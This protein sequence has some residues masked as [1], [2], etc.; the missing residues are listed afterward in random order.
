MLAPRSLTEV[1]GE[2]QDTQTNGMSLEQTPRTALNVIFFQKSRLTP[3]NSDV[4]STDSSGDG[5]QD[6]TKATRPSLPSYVDSFTSLLA[7]LVPHID[8]KSTRLLTPHI[9]Q[10]TYAVPY[11]DSPDFSSIRHNAPIRDFESKH[12]LEII[13]D[14]PPTASEGQQRPLRLALFDMDSTLINEEVIDELARSIGISDAVSAITARAMNGDIDFATSLSE[15]V[16]MLKGVRANIWEDLKKTI[17]IATGARELVSGLKEKGVLTGV[18]SG[19]FIQMANW[20]KGELGLDV[21]VAN[22]LLEEAPTADLPYP[23]LSGLLDPNYPIVTPE[24]KRATLKSLAAEH[25]IPL[26]ETLA[27]GDGSNDLLMLGTA[28]L[29][30]AWNAKEKVQTRAPMRLNGNSLADVLYLIC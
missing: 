21:A 23:H 10:S 9:Y 16:S 25:A 20:L 2:G 30:I 1:V 13:F 26:S 19:G 3:S 24:M 27:V 17:T 7:E 22:H 18:V 4:Q 11:Q 12:G 29:G 15:R 14:A 28:G 5:H 8:Y 6:E